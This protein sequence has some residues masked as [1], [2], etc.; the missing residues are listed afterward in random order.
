MFTH[1]DVLGSSPTLLLTNGILDVCFAPNDESCMEG[2]SFFTFLFQL[3][4]F[5]S[6]E[7][8]KLMLICTVDLS[9]SWKSTS[10]FTITV[11]NIYACMMFV[12]PLLIFLS[13]LLLLI[14]PPVH[15]KDVP[16]INPGPGLGFSLFRVVPATAAR[17]GVRQSWS[18]LARCK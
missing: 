16:P 9:S 7:L 18:K 11:P 14:C 10:T 3:C 15:Q 2:R 1:D 12:F 8:N 4:F 17:S 5:F 6:L 13:L